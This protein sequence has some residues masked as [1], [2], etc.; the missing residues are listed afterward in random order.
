MLSTVG[1]YQYEENPIP[2]KQGTNSSQTP[3]TKHVKEAIRPERFRGDLPSKFSRNCGYDIKDQPGTC[4]LPSNLF[5]IVNEQIC[6]LI[7]VSH[8]ECKN[9]I[10]SKET[11]DNIV[12][13]GEWSLRFFKEAKFEGRDPS[14]ID[15]QNNKKCL[16]NPARNNLI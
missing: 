3:K 5:L 6:R 1:S 7:Q 15:D 8:K 11:I 16:P 12:N 4:I 9:N 10:H 14:S 13:N 2:G